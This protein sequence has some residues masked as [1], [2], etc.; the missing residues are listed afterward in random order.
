MK[1]KVPVGVPG[2]L[3]YEPP[4]RLAARIRKLRVLLRKGLG[5]SAP[6]LSDSLWPGYAEA[7][8]SE[9]DFRVYEPGGP[10]GRNGTR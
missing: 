3:P 10:Y 6:E 2:A 5:L 4:A 1:S 8:R 9:H 7:F